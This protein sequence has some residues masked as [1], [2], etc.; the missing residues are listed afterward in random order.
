MA[1]EV[2]DRLL[3]SHARFIRMEGHIDLAAS[4]ASL[5][6]MPILQD[7]RAVPSSFYITFAGLEYRPILVGT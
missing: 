1:A 6:I 5:P 4:L 2:V 3:R 7:R